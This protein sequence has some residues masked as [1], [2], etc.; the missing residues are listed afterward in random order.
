MIKIT[1]VKPKLDRHVLNL[2]NGIYEISV[3][4]HYTEW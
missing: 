2:I 1:I 4:K 3:T